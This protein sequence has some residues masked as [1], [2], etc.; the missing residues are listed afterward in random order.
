M[1][2]QKEWYSHVFGE[3]RIVTRNWVPKDMVI[4]VGAVNQ[5]GFRDIIITKV[6]KVKNQEPA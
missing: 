1:K 6:K 4:T 5:D 3:F 2:K